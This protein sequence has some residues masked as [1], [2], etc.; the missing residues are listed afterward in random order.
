M[1]TMNMALMD[2]PDLEPLAAG[3]PKI[4]RKNGW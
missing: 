2:I 4:L 3:L 1:I